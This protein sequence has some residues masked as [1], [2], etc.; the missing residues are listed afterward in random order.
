MILSGQQNLVSRRLHRRKGD[1]DLAIQ[2]VSEPASILRSDCLS[3]VASGVGFG[4]VPVSRWLLRSDSVSAHTA[5]QQADGN[6]GGEAQD[7]P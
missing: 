5:F 1:I 7:G 6:S 4:V 3:Q 2:H